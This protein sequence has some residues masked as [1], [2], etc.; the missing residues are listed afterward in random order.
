[1]LRLRAGYALYGSPFKN[2]NKQGRQN[3]TGGIGL[4]GKNIY[5]DLAL[6]HSFYER[7]Y[8]PYNLE[9][10]TVPTAVINT[11]NNNAVLTVGFTF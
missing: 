10:I 1:M 5:A 6:V 3:I 4:R 11:T 2:L 7:Y 9:N 8:Q